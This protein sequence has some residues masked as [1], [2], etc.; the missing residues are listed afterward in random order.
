M[1]RVVRHKKDVTK[2]VE[3]LRSRP[4]EVQRLVDKNSRTMA[5]IMQLLEYM[6]RPGA[7]QVDK[8]GKISRYVEKLK[9]RMNRRLVKLSKWADMSY[10][11]RLPRMKKHDLRNIVNGGTYTAPTG[12]VNS[13]VYSNTPLHLTDMGPSN[14]AGTRGDVGVRRNLLAPQR[15]IIKPSDLPSIEEIMKQPQPESKG[16]ERPPFRFVPNGTPLYAFGEV[17]WKDYSEVQNVNTYCCVWYEGN[18]HVGPITESHGAVVRIG[19]GDKGRISLNKI[20]FR[21]P[22]FE[23]PDSFTEAD[24]TVVTA[25]EAAARRVKELYLHLTKHGWPQ[26]RES[27]RTSVPPLDIPEEKYTGFKGMISGHPE[28]TRSGAP[29]VPAQRK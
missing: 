1:V 29:A 3:V 17:P 9:A 20:M 21:S 19:P 12:Y 4:C 26:H 22:P 16:G 27:N 24:G 6:Q 7:E 15:C 13:V 8:G 25:K 14:P 2:A 5:K 28:C 18:F 10:E 11:E 23:K